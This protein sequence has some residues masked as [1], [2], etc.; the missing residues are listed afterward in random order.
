MIYLLRRLLGDLRT[1]LVNY[2]GRQ[3]DNFV[4]TAAVVGLLE[5]T[6]VWRITLKLRSWE[7]GVDSRRTSL[8]T[9]FQRRVEVVSV[10]QV[11]ASP[12]S[13]GTALGDSP[14]NKVDR[15]EEA[16]QEPKLGE[17][18][19]C[20]CGVVSPTWPPHSIRRLSLVLL[21]DRANF[22]SSCPVFGLL[23]EGIRKGMSS[24]QSRCFSWAGEGAR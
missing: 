13:G 11:A 5:C 7:C 18:S 21:L 2:L 12:G 16:T 19:Y 3:I 23:E 24:S 6:R 15:R 20:C 8:L 22:T 9:Q 1:W 14:L 17:G 10:S 4:L